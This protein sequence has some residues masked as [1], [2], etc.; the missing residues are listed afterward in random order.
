MAMNRQLQLQR[1]QDAAAGVAV[2]GHAY[3]CPAA[4]L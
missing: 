2:P 4:V 3:I 1:M